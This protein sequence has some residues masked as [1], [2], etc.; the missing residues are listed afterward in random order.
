[1]YVG[2]KGKGKGCR[3]FG[4]VGDSETRAFW[5]VYAGEQWGWVSGSGQCWFL[6]W[7]TS[8]VLLLQWARGCYN[9]NACIW[10]FTGYCFSGSSDDRLLVSCCHMIPLIT[11]SVLSLN[12]ILTLNHGVC[13]L[14]LNGRQFLLNQ[15]NVHEPKEKEKAKECCVKESLELLVEYVWIHTRPK[16]CKLG[17]SR[18]K[19]HYIIKFQIL[20]YPWY[21]FQ[22]VRFFVHLSS[23]INN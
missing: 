8:A 4:F 11:F 5:L 6:R 1:M 3:L 9:E 21:K 14:S 13:C 18:H 19:V 16:I 17:T 15:E 23:K 20:L 22:S 7:G 10:V 2:V 12:G